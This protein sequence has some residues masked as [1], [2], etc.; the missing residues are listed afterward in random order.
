LVNEDKLN[1]ILANQKILLRSLQFDP[2][3]KAKGVT[4]AIK[5][6]KKSIHLKGDK[7]CNKK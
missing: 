3:V 7:I 5:A 1:R 6:T 2:N 4:A